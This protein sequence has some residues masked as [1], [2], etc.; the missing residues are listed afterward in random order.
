MAEI[1]IENKETIAIVSEDS[2]GWTKEL[3][4]VSGND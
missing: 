1:K 4:L 3:N 2:K